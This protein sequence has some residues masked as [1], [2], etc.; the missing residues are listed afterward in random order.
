MRA[1]PEDFDNVQALHSPYGAVHGLGPNV[2][3]PSQMGPNNQAFGD[4][5]QRALMVDIRRPEAEANLSPTGLTPA[6]ESAGFGSV[7]AGNSTDLAS[8]LSSTP[9]DRFRQYGGPFSPSLAAITATNQGTLSGSQGRTDL[10]PLQTNHQGMRPLQPLR[11]SD[12]LSRPRADSARSPLR[13]SASWKNESTDFSSYHFGGGATVT[14]MERQQPGYHM[15]SSTSSNAGTFDA[16]SYS[17][18]SFLNSFWWGIV[19]D[20]Y[21]G[22]VHPAASDLSYSDFSTSP[23]QQRSRAASA[24]FPLS[25]DLRTQHRGLSNTSPE[26]NSSKMT[27]VS[28]HYTSSSIYTTSYPPAPLTAP[29]NIPQPRSSLTPRGSLSAHSEQQM[30]AS[31]GATANFSRQSPN[32]RGASSNTPMK[33]SFGETSFSFGQDDSRTMS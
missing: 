20:P 11:L 14:G 10:A 17:G 18:T 21:S 19:T 3:S 27:A 32:H 5:L 31:A 12:T 28:T 33:E 25:L 2:A 26:G 29:I 6:F 9:H 13:S 22:D 1:V 4:A 7:G 8:P 24:T 23:N 15:G 16:S 30:S